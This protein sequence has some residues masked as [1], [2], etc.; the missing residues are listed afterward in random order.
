MFTIDVTDEEVKALTQSILTRYGIDFTCYEPKSLKRRVIRV[1]SVFNFTSIH[2]LWIKLLRDSL[3]IYSFMNEISVGMTSM[4]R[5]PMFWKV[6]KNKVLQDFSDHETISVWH[7]GCSTGEEVYSMSILM[8]ELGINS[9]C[10]TF[11]TDINQDAM[12]E[13]RKGVYHK[14]KMIEN[15]RNYKEYNEYGNFSSYYTTDGKN[16]IMKPELISNVTFGYHNLINDSML[17]AYD[18]VFCRNVMIYFDHAAK[19]K[20]IEK[21]FDVLK[22]GGYFITGFCDTMLPIIEERP[23]VAAD[24]ESRIFMKAR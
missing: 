6:L 7:A 2:E 16:A 14:I 11:A 23:L 5:D 8:R 13:A 10:R 1:L 24:E 15:E 4:F 9:K 21:F 17:G 18:I 3:F 12:Q 19:V 22:P 20:L